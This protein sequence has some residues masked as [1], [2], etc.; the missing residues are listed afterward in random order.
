M[1][2]KNTISL[3]LIAFISSC[4]TMEMPN[5]GPKDTSPPVI[6]SSVPEN[7]SLNM[8]EKIIEIKFD[9][10][11]ELKNINQQLII[12]PP[13]KENPKFKVKAKSLIIE[14]V[15]SLH[16][17]TTYSI[18]FGDAIVNFTE[19]LPIK[20]FSYTFSTGD[21]IDTLQVKGNVINAFDKTPAKDVYALLYKADDDSVLYKQ[22]PYYVTKTNENGE[23]LFKNIGDFEYSIYALK[24]INNN[25]IYDSR[26]EEIAFLE[27]K[28]SPYNPNPEIDSAVVDSGAIDIETNNIQLTLFKEENKQKILI[29]NKIVAKNEVLLEF[30]REMGNLCLYPIG[31]KPDTNWYNI[32]STKDANIFSV[33]FSKIIEDTFRISVQ[34]GETILDTIT[35]KFNDKLKHKQFNVETNIAEKFPFYDSISLKLTNPLG[36]YFKDSIQLKSLKDSL[37]EEVNFEISYDERTK[38]IK[39]IPDFHEK[40]KYKFIVKDSAISD[41]NNSFLLPMEKTFSTTEAKQYGNLLL[42]VS[43]EVGFPIIIE[44]YDSGGKLLIEKSIREDGNINYEWLKEGKYTLKAI[45]DANENGK[46]DSGDLKLKKQAEKVFIYNGNIEIRANWDTEQ[47]WIINNKSK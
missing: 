25:Y 28:V 46:W 40:R 12:S 5:G 18:F 1:I 23:F 30:N 29:S 24:D 22:K 35:I 11:I 47:S 16:E 17:N 20:N 7:N 15:D 37:W 9:E 3:V 45:Y 43:V 32:Y 4:A 21:I 41:Y 42:K 2:F 33:F 36:V 14:I 13:M 39:I 34:D 38:N 26:D 44:L 27:E 6:L 8:K 31:F 10:Y 19:G